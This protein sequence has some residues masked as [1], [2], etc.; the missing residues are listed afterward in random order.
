VTD[1]ALGEGA[2]CCSRGLPREIVSFI[3]PSWNYTPIEVDW[4]RN[5][6]PTERIELLN[7]WNF[8]SVQA[9]LP[10]S[11]P[12]PRSWEEL[13]RM[14]EEDCNLLEFANDAFAPLQGY[15]FSP[16]A[17]DRIQVLLNVLNKLKGCFDE[18]G[19]RTAEGQ[20][21]Y[22]Q[23]FTG[24]KAWFSDSSNSEKIDFENELSFPHPSAPDSTLFCPWHGKVKTPQI[25][26]HFTW[27]VTATTRLYLAYIGPKITKR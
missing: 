22:E 12:T 14:V 2:V 7:H 20:Y 6:L 15:P 27:P 16:A 19:E 4:V 5:N 3:H 26:I 17:A 24:P 23:H 21:L 9:S 8:E 11:R 13:S 10:K 1:T 25:R 18:N